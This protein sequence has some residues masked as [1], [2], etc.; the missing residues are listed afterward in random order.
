MSK[1]NSLH[2]NIT[3]L[4]NEINT[5][6][7]D[8]HG[9]NDLSVLDIDLMR[10]HVIDLYEQVNQLRL[11]MKEEVEVEDMVEVEVEIE[12]A[13][14]PVEMA[15]PI[16]EEIEK[17]IAE[18][19]TEETPSTENVEEVVQ[20]PIEK[21]KEPEPKA[22]KETSTDSHEEEPNDLAS[23]FS[24][25]PISD[26]KQ[27]ISIA[28]KFEMIN[29]LFG[30]DVQMYSLAIHHINNLQSGDDAFTYLHQMKQERHWD[31]EDKNFMEL[32]NLV[33]RRFLG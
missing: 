8:M 1:R 9:R 23:K 18:S 15:P 30:G 25:T 6:N 28:K 20:E 2:Q 27:A 12:A 22:K 33:R 16:V 31:E 13:E 4:L 3:H 32:A 24:N 11:V 26:L 14:T 17:P 7:Q 21:I 29:S 10:K 19:N 5:L